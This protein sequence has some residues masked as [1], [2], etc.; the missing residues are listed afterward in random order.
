MDLTHKVR[1]VDGGHLNPYVPKH[2][3]YSSVVSCESVRICF[4]LA[5]LNGQNV[6]SRNIGNA[7][8]NAKLL[9]KCY[10]VVRDAYLLGPS[11]I[12]KN[13]MI[14]RALYGMKSSGN[15]WRLHVGNM[16]LFQ[17]HIK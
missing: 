17:Y 9:E 13:A 4:P 11:A 1:L 15:A 2:I 8:L 10:V 7:Y 14:V 6:L 12:G 5:A 16:K 3:S